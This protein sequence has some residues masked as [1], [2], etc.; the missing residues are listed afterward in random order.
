MSTIG[1]KTRN[2][3]IEPAVNVLLYAR[4]KNAST[5]AQ[6][7]TINARVIIARIERKGSPPTDVSTSRGTKTCVSA[8]R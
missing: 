6:I 4:A 8:P 5:F 1:P 3:T 2:A 7:E